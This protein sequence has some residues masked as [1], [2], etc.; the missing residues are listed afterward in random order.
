MVF[1]SLFNIQYPSYL[2]ENKDQLSAEDLKRYTKQMDLMKEVCHEFDAESP[3]DSEAV[4][5]ERFQRIL[6]VMQSMQGCGSPPTQLI[7][8][9]PDLTAGLPDLKLPDIACGEGQGQP[10]CLLM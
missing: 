1:I 3:D 10:Q 8:D 6:L 2:E 5:K 4:K 7:G 9:V